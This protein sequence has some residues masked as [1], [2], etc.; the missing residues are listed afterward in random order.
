M[1]IIREIAPHDNIVLAKIIRSSLEEFKANKRG[2]VYYDET[3][4]HLSNLFK[5]PGSKYFVA[6]EGQTVLGGAGIFPTAGLPEGTCELV[7]MYLVPECRG[8]GIG[9]ALINQCLDFAKSIGQHSVYIETLPELHIAVKVYEHMGFTRLE[10][11]LGDSKHTGC[12]IWM[13]KNI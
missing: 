5:T 4:D 10:A 9:K 3:T 7:K 11:P 12:S 8:L 2:T 1:Y 6:E 13:T